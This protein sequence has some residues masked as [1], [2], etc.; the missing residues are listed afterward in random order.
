M[1][2]WICRPPVAAGGVWTSIAEPQHAASGKRQGKARPLTVPAGWS[3]QDPPDRRAQAAVTARGKL[4]FDAMAETHSGN[5]AADHGVVSGICAAHGDRPE[6]LIEIFHE[7]QAAIG[8]IPAESLDVIA[9]AINLSR[10]EVHGVFSFYHDFRDH[11]AGRHVIRLC[12]AEACQSVGC[13]ALAAHAEARL[14]T[15]FGATSAD[16]KVTLEAV[17]CLGNCALGPAAMI[18]GKLHGMLNNNKLD[19][20]IEGLV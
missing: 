19:K 17:Y 11:P 18:D 5:G 2:G 1:F 4:G 9:K 7:V 14:G 20:L 8:C 6:E 16:G 10:A 3:K 15:A 12:R 13:E